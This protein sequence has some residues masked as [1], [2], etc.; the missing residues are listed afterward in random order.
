M[1]LTYRKRVYFDPTSH[2]YLLDGEVLLMGV[3]ELLAK[4]G[5]SAD[6]SGIKKEVLDNA[7]KIGTELHREIQDYLEGKTIFA[8][9]LIDEVKKLNLKFVE[10]EYPVSDY[11]TVASAIDLVC[12]GSA[13]DK[14][15]LIDIK[16]TEKYHR[17]PV[18]WQLGGY[19]EMFEAQNQGIKVEALF[20]LHIDKKARKIRGFYPV[21]GVTSEEWNALL[22]AERNGLIYIDEN[23]IPDAALVL[24]EDELQTYVAQATKIAELKATIKEIEGAMKFCDER[25]LAY[26]AEN[27]LDEMAAPGGVFKRKAAYTQTRVD[28]TALKTKFPAVYEKVAKTTEVAASLSFK[29]NKQ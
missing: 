26:M 13:P 10:A 29:P 7:A 12:E 17:R 11:K 24:E 8:T 14:A 9:D 25:L 6:Y 4:H 2:S 19:K 27:N 3:T 20:C 22:E 5:L 1:E 23:A 15:I 18:E 16:S 28:S 21:E